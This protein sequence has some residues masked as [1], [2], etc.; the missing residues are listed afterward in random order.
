LV[1][2][3]FLT[4]LAHPTTVLPPQ[5]PLSN[6]S[7]GSA[8]SDSTTGTTPNSPQTPSTPPWR[9]GELTTAA[10]LQGLTQVKAL[11]KARDQCAGPQDQ[12][13][14]GVQVSM[15]QRETATRPTSR[16]SSASSVRSAETV[17][18][19]FG[20]SI[21]GHDVAIDNIKS[22]NRDSP[23]R[24]Q[25]IPPR[26]L[27][28]LNIL[29]PPGSRPTGPQGINDS[30]SHISRPPRTYSTS[31]QGV[32]Q[33]PVSGHSASASYP[34]TPSGTLSSSTV[35]GPERQSPTMGY[36]FSDLN[37]PRKVL[38]PKMPRPSSL[39][40]SSGLP[41]EID[42]RPQAYVPSVAPAKRPYNSDTPNKTRQLPSLHHTPGIA[43]A[44][45][46][47]TLTPPPRSRAPD[48]SHVL[49]QPGHPRDISG[50]PRHPHTQFQPSSSL[51]QLPAVSRPPEGL[52]A[53]SE[54]M[55]RSSMGGPGVLEGQQA[56]MTLPGSD[57]PIP[58]Q[59]DYSQASKKA[60]E[61]RQRNA[62]AS[63][64]HRRKKK[65]IQEENVRQLQD[66]RDEREQIAE[67]L[68][69]MRHQRDFYR[70]ERNRLRDIVSRTHGIHQ[71]AAGP[72]SPT[73]TRSTGS[74]TDR[75]PATQH[76]MSTP[77]PGYAGD[78]VSIDR[79]GQRPKP[80][81]RPEYTGPGFIPGMAPAALTSPHGQPY[82][83]VTPRPPSAASSGSGDRLPPLR[84]MEGPSPVVQHLG[85]R[86]GH[87]QDPT[88]G[89]W[90]PVPPR[91]VETG[92]A[93]ASRKL[94]E[95]Q[96]QSHPW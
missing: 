53:W 10:S 41:R 20:P 40:Q 79:T 54:V 93:T 65:T 47:Q 9:E 90:R 66:L 58:V 72:P 57:T 73:P 3:L 74:H 95:G 92:W 49:A 19:S 33:Q 6:D 85:S 64:R 88:T 89:Q 67:E 50:M 26:S 81:E 24:G 25:Q 52:T 46:P 31:M 42:S 13:R 51:G 48:V 91:Q 27:G 32:P 60:D 2:I 16:R 7:P 4:N 75:S 14:S 36:S 15:S 34:G 8:V 12:K 82:G 68:E 44:A 83:V 87:E 45:G 80:E 39:G 78:V 37:E 69:H 35:L 62:K 96:S 56:F 18:R 61:K 38:S 22:Q 30:A 23:S 77:T 63:T 76:H 21:S 17:T 11:E 43:Q 94:G 71:H 5:A 59:V 1:L 55:R 86:Q 29:N 28:M 84:A 70:D